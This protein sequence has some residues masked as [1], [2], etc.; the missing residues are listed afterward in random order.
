MPLPHILAVTRFNRKT[1]LE[2][3]LWRQ[4]NAYSGCIYGSPVRIK[5]TILIDQPIFVLEMQNDENR[6]KGIGLIRNQVLLKQYNIYPEEGNYNRY[7]YKSAFRLDRTA[8]NPAEEKIIAMFD[9]L[10]F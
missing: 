10:L 1:S 7:I 5:E 3:D 2:N 6:I 8:L 4:Q 9:V